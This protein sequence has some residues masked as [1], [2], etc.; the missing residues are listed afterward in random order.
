MNGLE[1]EKKIIAAIK[2]TRDTPRRFIVLTV[3]E[4]I[5]ALSSDEIL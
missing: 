4:V 2:K 5:V 1:I 3:T